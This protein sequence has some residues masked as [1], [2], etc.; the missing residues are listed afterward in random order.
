[1]KLPAIFFIFA[2]SLLLSWQ[3][4]A[5][6]LLSITDNKTGETKIIEAV[7]SNRQ[8]LSSSSF[9]MQGGHEVFVHSASFESGTYVYLNDKIAYALK[10]GQIVSRYLLSDDASTAVLKVDKGTSGGAGLWYRS[11]L[12]IRSIQ[13]DGEYLLTMTNV[14]ESDMLMKLMKGR[15]CAVLKILD[16]NNYPEV[17]MEV[18][19][20]EKPAWTNRDGEMSFK[21]P[22]FDQR[23]N[24]ET[25]EL[26]TSKVTARWLKT[27][28]ETD[29][30]PL[31]VVKED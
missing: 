28:G 10:P 24:L 8:M 30:D 15:E 29:F 26:L 20:G 11:L 6:D 25:E 19:I 5:G 3:A 31:D 4:I 1:M 14:M 17:E 21:T 27:H 22:W 2:G 9:M 23:W 12:V 13:V 16:V 18:L 7:P